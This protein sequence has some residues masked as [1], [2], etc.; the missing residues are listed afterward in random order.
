MTSV[1][2]I[3]GLLLVA[4]GALFCYRF[5][6]IPWRIMT[7]LGDLRRAANA[8]VVLQNYVEVLHQGQNQAFI[9]R[10]AG[11][12][13]PS[14]FSHG[15]WDLVAGDGIGWEKDLFYK[16]RGLAVH[17]GLLFAG[18]T[19]PAPDG[20]H[21]EVWRLEMGRWTCVGSERMGPWKSGHSSVEHLLSTSAGLVVAERRGVWLLDRSGWSF[22]G[23]GLNCG[24]KSGPYC[25]SEWR[26]Q[27]VA[28]HWGEP[29]VSV[30]QPDSTW[31]YLPTPPR[32]WGEGART[33][34][35]M[36]AWNGY[37]YVGTG[38]GKFQGPSSTVWRF[39]GNDWEQVAGKG[40]R[41]SWLSDG[42]PF[43]LSLTPFK[44]R[45][46]ATLSRPPGLV[47][48]AS[49]VWIF[50]GVQWRALNPGRV[51]KPMADSLI[52][53][54]AVIFRD[55]LIVATGHSTRAPAEIWELGDSSEWRPVGPSRLKQH[56]SGD[57]GWWVYKLC[58]DGEHLY[59]STAGHRGAATILRFSPDVRD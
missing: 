43:V 48:A 54:D 9:T 6:H 31:T 18:I 50:D 4:V 27:L 16:V 5:R 51:P 40:I 8:T 46:I 17:E 44:D 11:E 39:D 56:G 19:G 10:S 49:N 55:R 15:H 29:R 30:M 35:S 47:A 13:K 45:L 21:G 25:F 34:Y 41:G 37:L 3:W 59:A 53:N 28:G 26:G 22:A 57:G 36:A 12:S 7:F 42:I 14:P 20:P 38:T 32:G 52:M 23:S 1:T 24:E 2:L 58:A 33:I